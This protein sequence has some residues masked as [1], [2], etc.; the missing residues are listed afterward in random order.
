MAH[1]LTGN[2]WTLDGSVVS[3]TPVW[4]G[5]VWVSEFEMIDYTLDTDTVQVKDGFGRIVWEGNG[6]SD[7]RPVKSGRIG[8]CHGLALTASSNA[9]TKVRL[10]VL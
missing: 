3:A 1:V 2:V 5:Q 9:L 7:L 4:T 10:G 8:T 6:A